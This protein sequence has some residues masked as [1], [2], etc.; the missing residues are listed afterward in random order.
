[1]LLQPL[2]PRPSSCVQDKQQRNM[3]SARHIAHRILL[4]ASRRIAIAVVAVAGTTITGATV[5]TIDHVA[6]IHRDYHPVIVGSKGPNKRIHVVLHP[7]CQV[8]RDGLG[9]WG[10]GGIE[11]EVA[12]CV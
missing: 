2:G 5:T 3:G 12:I 7:P 6:T 1:M 4:V 11:V 10:N 9:H 8:T